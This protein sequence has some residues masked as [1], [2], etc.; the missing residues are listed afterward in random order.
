MTVTELQA[1]YNYTEHD[2][3]SYLNSI[4][5]IES[6][7]EPN[8]TIVV[9]SLSY[10]EKLGAL[11]ARTNRRVLAN[12]VMWRNAMSSVS[13]LPR[14]FRERQQEYNKQKFGTISSRIR[15]MECVEKALLYYPHALGALYVRK[16]FNRAAKEQALEMV[17]N[18]KEEMKIVLKENVWMD[19]ETKK[20]AIIK[21]DMI[22]E[23]I[24]YADE[25]LNDTKLAEYYGT[26]PVTVNESEYYE[27][28]SRIIAA[29]FNRN[30]RN[31]REPIDKDDWTSY[32]TPAVVNAYYTRAEN[33]I[34]FPAGILQGIFFNEKRPHYMNYGSIGFIIGHEI[35]RKL[36]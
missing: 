35:T 29:Y 1:T 9:G 30:H 18:I 4:L 27:S 14:I 28:A 19:D 13:F 20:E 22:R 24:G 16:H 21:V 3:L 34:K 25:L 11:M 2:W 6:Q 36:L 33:F 12:Y 32:I 23:Q 10:F 7:L 5:P 8:D 31:L 15:W 17:G 26:F